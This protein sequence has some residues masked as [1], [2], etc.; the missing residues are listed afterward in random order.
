MMLLLEKYIGE[1][2]PFWMIPF[3][4]IGYALVGI[5]SHLVSLPLIAYAKKQIAKQLK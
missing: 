5:V 2:L 4:I 1:P 3:D